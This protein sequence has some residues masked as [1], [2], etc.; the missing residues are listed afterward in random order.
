MQNKNLMSPEQVLEWYKKVVTVEESKLEMSFEMDNCEILS[1]DV[2]IEKVSTSKEQYLNARSQGVYK[3]AI[4]N[5]P[6]LIVYK[7]E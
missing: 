7:L 3:T 5:V 6:L 2:D 1:P 4:V